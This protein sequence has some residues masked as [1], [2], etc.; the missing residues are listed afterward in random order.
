ML[1]D[2]EGQLEIAMG[3]AERCE[4]DYEGVVERINKRIAKTAAFRDS[5]LEYFDGKRARGKMAELIG[6]LVTEHRQLSRERSLVI[7]QQEVAK[8]K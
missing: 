7:E 8:S 6:E 3:K 1:N 4:P 2:S 5:A